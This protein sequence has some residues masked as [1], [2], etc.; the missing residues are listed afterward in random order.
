MLAQCPALAFAL[1]HHCP[2]EFTAKSALHQGC[3][4]SGCLQTDTRPSALSP[5]TQTQLLGSIPASAI[6]RRNKSSPLLTLLL[7]AEGYWGILAYST[8]AKKGK[9][10]KQQ[11]LAMSGRQFFLSGCQSHWH[12]SFI[13]QTWVELL[14]VSSLGPGSGDLRVRHSAWPP[15]AHTL[16]REMNV[17]T[18]KSP[19]KGCSTQME[20]VSCPTG[21]D[22]RPNIWKQVC[23]MCQKIKWGKAGPCGEVRSRNR[24]WWREPDSRGHWCRAENKG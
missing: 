22:I 18:A 14:Q 5:S 24:R 21:G 23:T 9:W 7:A 20:G 8:S 17:R 2:V 19:G 11:D 16:V 10:K 6:W 4:L 15:G 12:P 1:C 13:P 3:S